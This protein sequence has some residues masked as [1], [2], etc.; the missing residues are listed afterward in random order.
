[1]LISILV[2]SFDVRKEID[3]YLLKKKIA[4]KDFVHVPS[5]SFCFVYEWDEDV[6]PY[7]GLAVK[8]NMHVPCNL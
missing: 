3:V 4:N 7:S 8:L 1:M 5:T 6:L 2:S